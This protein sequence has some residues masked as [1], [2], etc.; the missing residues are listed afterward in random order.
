MRELTGAV[1]RV[2]PYSHSEVVPL[3]CFHASDGSVDK[4]LSS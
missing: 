1:C 3:D 4:K 2:G